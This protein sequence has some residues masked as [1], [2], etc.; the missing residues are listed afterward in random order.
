MGTPVADMSYYG[1]AGSVGSRLTASNLTEFDALQRQ[2]SRKDRPRSGLHGEPQTRNS[3][4]YLHM[5]QHGDIS[6]L[7]RKRCNRM[8]GS[9][10]MPCLEQLFSL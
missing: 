7:A 6:S 2:M 5:Y 8:H 1:S 3:R 4:S 9:L 10:Q